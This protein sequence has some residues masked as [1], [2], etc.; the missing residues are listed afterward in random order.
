MNIILRIGLI[1]GVLLFLGILLVFL[2]KK[3]LNLNYS[4]LWMMFGFA[5]LIIGIFPG[6]ITFFSRL[7]GIQT[8]SNTIF[9]F[10]IFL[11]LVILLALTSI[12]SR[13][14]REIKKLIQ[15]LALTQKELSD[16]KKKVDKNS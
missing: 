16:V 2:R 8:P 15:N 4:L 11:V 3:S 14:H 13:Q 9:A 5:L 10:M 6:I 7:L 1:V 12:V